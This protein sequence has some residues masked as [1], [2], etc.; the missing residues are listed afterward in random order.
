[1]AKAG[2]KPLAKEKPLFAKCGLNHVTQLVEEKKAKLVVIA[3]DVNPVEL[4]L[5]LPALCRKMGVPYAIVNN[6]GR[7]GSIVH[8]KKS[9]VVALTDVRSEDK[10]A[11]EKIL[12]IANAKFANNRD[13]QRKWGGGKMGLKTNA[14]LEKR[15]KAMAAEAAK[16]AA[17]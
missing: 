16:R 9:A 14:S 3:A 8:L 4:V 17:L 2:G 11:L 1:M 7:L 10:A 15:A 6:K 12:D 13:L 5:W